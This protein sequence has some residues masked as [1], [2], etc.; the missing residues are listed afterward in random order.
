MNSRHVTAAIIGAVGAIIVAFIHVSGVWYQ[1]ER[2]VRSEEQRFQTTIAAQEQND[3]HSS[4]THITS[5][6][7]V[8]IRTS[9]TKHVYANPDECTDVAAWREPVD[10]WEVFGIIAADHPNDQDYVIHYGDAVRLRASSGLYISADEN[11][12][13]HLTTCYSDE[14][15]WQTFTLQPGAQGNTGEKGE[16]F[17]Y[18]QTF[19]LQ[20]HNNLYV[21]HD[22]DDADRMKASVEHLQEWETFTAIRP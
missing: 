16:P 5:M 8:A 18:G 6:S 2:Q 12:A 19:G 22:R 17:E 14:D 13:R 1:T 10:R 21:I 3:T 7:P 15:E 4:A 11:R 20:T 9:D